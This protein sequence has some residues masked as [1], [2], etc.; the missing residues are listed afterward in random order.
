LS[1]IP[2]T[3]DRFERFT[4][5]TNP[6]Q[7]FTSSSLGL[8]GSISLYA[9][10]NRT[11]KEVEN[12][13]T[14]ALAF[15]D[16]ALPI[17]VADVSR[18]S[19][20]NQR[21][22]YDSLLTSISQKGLSSRMQK[23]VSV[24]RYTP[25]VSTVTSSFLKKTVVKDLLFPYYKTTYS[26]P[27]YA[28]T[29]YHSL[30]F[31]TAS[32]VLPG[33]TMIYPVSYSA[34]TPMTYVPTGGFTLDMYVNPRYAVS[35]SQEF[36]AGTILHVSSTLALS[37]VTGSQVDHNGMRTGFRLLLQLSHSADTKP[38]SVNLATANNQRA[39]PDDM[40][41]VSS[42]NAL[43]WNHWHH[44]A[45]RW[46][47]SNTN[48]GTGSFLIDGVERGTFIVPSGSVTR[49]H[50]GSAAVYLG[51]YFEGQ[52]TLDQRKFFNNKA[53]YN[54]GVK[55]LSS[56]TTDPTGFTFNHPLNAEIHDIKIFDGYRSVQQTLTASA[57]GPDTLADL[58][59]YVPVLFTKVT[60]LRHVLQTPI[61]QSRRSTGEPLNA[62]LAMRVNGHEI[63]VENFVRE[64]V[65][66]EHPR[67]FHMTGT[68]FTGS[69][70]STFT[71]NDYLKRD[72]NI[73]K[74]NLLVLPCDNGLFAPN[75]D[76][77]RS[78]TSEVMPSSGSVMERFVTDL[79]GLD[80]K[81]ITLRNLISTA[82]YQA[83]VSGSLE[84]DVYGASPTS[85][86][87]AP[88][89]IYAVLQ[90][91]RD[92]SSNDIVFFEVSNLMYGRRIFPGT[93]ELV[94]HNITGSSGRIGMKLKDDGRGGLYRADCL[95]TQ[96]EWNTL[97]NVFYNEGLVLVKTPN[98]PFF[99]QNNFTISFKGERQIYVSKVNVVAP[100]AQ[101]NSSSNPAFQDVPVS[102][103]AN[104]ADESF[105]Y[106]TGINLHDENLNVIARAS[107]AQ[108]IVKRSGDRILFRL[109][110]DY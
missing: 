61:T 19:G 103:N 38:S 43:L 108:P 83:S 93:L 109:A 14:G 76:L 31:F 33:G 8:T 95:T 106:I 68:I 1:F 97:G 24:T 75:F 41:F 42:D 28:Y 89:S 22:S 98:I 37:L 44:V 36:K 34:N 74:R 11:I 107:L 6:S 26:S 63:N 71:A 96:A 84:T 66:G 73:A 86:T 4:L 79:G 3:P 46:G 45:V 54:E 94:D 70:S 23:T 39:I 104:E 64:F 55:Q 56:D 10:Q 80:L 35:A 29:N 77:L 105:V 91:T 60:P 58:L 51:N 21:G 85:P 7:E 92:P 69:L 59:F 48:N 78:G 20:S 50:S 16:V 49:Q 52:P 32:S 17:V 90:A 2:L 53:S 88:T 13:L 72:V 27:N 18:T 30:N 15:N 102:L 25:S 57:Q 101:V 87:T 65:E 47:T 99:G 81:S 62:E 40:I 110:L 100:S 82:S 5:V 67:L 12:P 9:R